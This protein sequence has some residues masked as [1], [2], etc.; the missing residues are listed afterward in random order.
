MLAV[1]YGPAVVLW[2]A[3]SLARLAVLTHAIVSDSIE[4][5]E[6]LRNSATLVAASTDAVAVWDLRTCAVRYTLNARAIGLAVHPTKPEFA[7]QV[8]VCVCVCT[9]EFVF[10]V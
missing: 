7:L 8:C 6:F 9:C 1:S 4:R 5:L 2:S 10:C 3:D